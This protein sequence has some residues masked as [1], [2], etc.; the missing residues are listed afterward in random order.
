MIETALALTDHRVDGKRIEQIIGFGKEI[1]AHPVEL[2]D[3]VLDTV[4]HA[5]RELPAGAHHQG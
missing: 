1:L 2:I 4:R 5:G 3:G